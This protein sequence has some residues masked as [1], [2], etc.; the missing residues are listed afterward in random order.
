ML[1]I[2][3]KYN[4]AIVYTDKLDSQARSQIQ[5]VCDQEAFSAS[6]IRIM[7]DVH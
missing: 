5:S 4:S 6:K 7:S 2:K 1:K 3:G